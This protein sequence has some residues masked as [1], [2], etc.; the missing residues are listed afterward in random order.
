MVSDKVITETIK[1]M[2]D[3]GLEDSVIIDTLKDIGLSEKQ[4]KEFIAGVSGIEEPEEESEEIAEKTAQKIRE[5][6]DEERGERE[7]R[8]TTSHAALIEHGEKLGELHKTVS[9]LASQPASSEVL[10]EIQLIKAEL[11]SI[12]EDLSETKALSAATKSL[13]EKILEANRKI[14]SKME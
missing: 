3:S 12:K 10:R 4:A 13:M 8:E 11:E 2:K 9:A 5:H 6:L 1:R 7:L 14:L